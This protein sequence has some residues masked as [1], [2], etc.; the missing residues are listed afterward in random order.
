MK[1]ISVFLIILTVILFL[2]MCSVV[3]YNYYALLTGTG[4]SAPAYVAFLL[5]IPFLIGITICLISA[6]I[7]RKCV[8]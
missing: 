8:K 6:L 2:I 1:K 7:I 5:G 3:A 4:N